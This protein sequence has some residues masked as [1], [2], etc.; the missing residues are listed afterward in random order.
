MEFYNSFLNI[1]PDIISHFPTSALP[2]TMALLT[3]L[4][5]EVI[6]L[7][8][9]FI[10]W[11][12]D[13]W[14]GHTTWEVGR[15]D[16]KLAPY[17]GISRSW[18]HAIERLTFEEVHIQSSELDDF[19]RIMSPRRSQ[20]PYHRNNRRAYLKELHFFITFPEEGGRRI[21][22]YWAFESE[23]EQ[24]ATSESFTRMMK[25]LFQMLRLWYDDHDDH[26]A[27]HLPPTFRLTLESCHGSKNFTIFKDHNRVDVENHT[28]I[29][30]PAQ[31][32]LLERRYR[33]SMLR[34]LGDP[35]LDGLVDVPQVTFFD[36]YVGSGAREF[37]PKSL[38]RLASKCPN[39][40][41]IAFWLSDNEKKC[42]ARRQSVRY[43]G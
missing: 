9:G 12:E 11:P 26:D 4:P 5:T 41:D 21:E 6:D 43:G 18:Q 35:N 27:A 34:L 3:T 16:L 23:E 1:L 14:E 2:M 24:Q 29:E 28:Y 32:G 37:E 39:S 30:L 13:G 36:S 7:I 22:N 10:C 25:A 33:H 15:L 8:I 17:A 19:A 31:R 40:E 20:V 38:A 42:V